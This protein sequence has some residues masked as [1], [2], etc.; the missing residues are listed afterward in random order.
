MGILSKEK[1][2]YSL[3]FG[4]VIVLKYVSRVLYIMNLK[5]YMC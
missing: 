3:I 1:G 4:D 5:K 2:S